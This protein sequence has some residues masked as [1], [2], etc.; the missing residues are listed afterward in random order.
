MRNILAIIG[1]A[2]LLGTSAVSAQ[3]ASAGHEQHQHAKPKP[4]MKGGCCCAKDMAEMKSM[5]ADMM[6]MHHDMMQQGMKMPMDGKTTPPT[7]EHKH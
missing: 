2:L 1:A 3:P 5:M 4:A 7:D 6:K